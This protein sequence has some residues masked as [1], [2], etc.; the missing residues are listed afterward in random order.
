MEYETVQ[1]KHGIRASATTAVERAAVERAA[2][3][4]AAEAT[5]TAMT[6]KPAACSA[7]TS[8]RNSTMRAGPSGSVA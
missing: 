2:V 5:R 4:R 3:E 7:M 6:R 8:L 1:P